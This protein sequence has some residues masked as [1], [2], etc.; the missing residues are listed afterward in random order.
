[1]Q[2]KLQSQWKLLGNLTVF[3]LSQC[4]SKRFA[5][6]TT[7]NITERG[8]GIDKGRVEV[9]QQFLSKTSAVVDIRTCRI[10]VARDSKVFF[11][12][13]ERV[14]QPRSSLGFHYNIKIE[15]VWP[16]KRIQNFREN[17]KIALIIF[18][19]Y[20]LKLDGVTSSQVLFKHKACLH[21]VGDPGLVGLVSFVF[22]LWW[23]QNKRN[24]PHWTGVSHSM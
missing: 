2:I 19:I 6:L 3:R 4:W 16:R 24:L 12:H 22:T 15:Q 20:I 10:Q 7:I 5:T 1:M 21:G 11:C 17:Y 13:L 8:D 18:Y 23:T 9:S 14:F